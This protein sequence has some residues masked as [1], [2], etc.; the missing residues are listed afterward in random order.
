MANNLKTSISASNVS[1]SSNQSY[2]PVLP[3]NSQVN[4]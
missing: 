4:Q 1:Q 2:Q 3:K